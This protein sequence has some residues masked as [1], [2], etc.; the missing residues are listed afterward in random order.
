MLTQKKVTKK[1]EEYKEI[2][3]L[4]KRVFPKNELYP[5]W[6]LM[7]VSKFKKVDFTAYYEED[8]DSLRSVTYRAYACGK[9]EDSALCLSYSKA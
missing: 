2:G 3:E 8:K 7:L 4:M 9:F 1:L 5:M 6:Y